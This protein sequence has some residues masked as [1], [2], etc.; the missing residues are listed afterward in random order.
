MFNFWYRFTWDLTR[1][2]AEWEGV[3]RPFSIR[4]AQPE[5][6]DIVLRDSLYAISMDASLGDS[7]R[8]V[9]EL[10]H[11]SVDD[12][13]RNEPPNCFVI[14]HG[15]R[16]IALSVFS[17][18]PDA[19]NHLLS[20]PCVLHEYRSRGLAT[21][22]TAATLYALRDIGL[23]QAF[24]LAKNNSSLARYVYPK[25]PGSKDI[26]EMGPRSEPRLTAG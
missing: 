13:F 16:I 18:Q 9:Q 7:V 24:G 3:P 5:E 19:E 2:P 22:L 23:T 12:A 11:K 1:L 15:S 21:F 20:G 10:L 14:A 8:M 17:T 6:K 26:Y 25:F 4:L